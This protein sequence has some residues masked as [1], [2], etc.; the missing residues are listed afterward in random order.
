MVGHQKQEHKDSRYNYNVLFEQTP[1][2]TTIKKMK[3]MVKDGELPEFFPIIAAE[4]GKRGMS[5]NKYI[6]FMKST[7]YDTF[8]DDKI[9][10][11]ESRYKKKKQNLESIVK[12][13]SQK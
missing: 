9:K 5:I 8:L 1:N 7:E 2:A 13:G 10:Q 12:R 4:A 11:L 3:N 6:E